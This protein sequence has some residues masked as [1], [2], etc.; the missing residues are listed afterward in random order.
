[1]DTTDNGFLPVLPIPIF[2]VLLVIMASL[3]L[4]TVF[5]PPGLF[6]ALNTLFLTIF[7]LSVVYFATK[8]YLHSGF[9]TMLMLGSGAL[10]LG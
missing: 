4:E 6:A 5:D 1:M 3:N 2:L 7:P 9:F 10:T 8:G